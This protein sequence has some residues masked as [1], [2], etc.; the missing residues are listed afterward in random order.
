MISN[1]HKVHF[2][3]NQNQYPLIST[4]LLFKHQNVR[5]VRLELL[6]KCV[7]FKIIG[8]PSSNVV[9]V[10]KRHSPIQQFCICMRWQ[11]V[12]PASLTPICG[13]ITIDNQTTRKIYLELLQKIILKRKYIHIFP[14]NLEYVIKHQN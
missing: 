4:Y 5:R 11:C 3:K 13:T 2:I 6:K 8:E 12:D 7:V 14:S 10:N 9:S 1:L